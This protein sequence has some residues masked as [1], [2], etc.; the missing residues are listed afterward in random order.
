MLEQ[1]KTLKAEVEALKANH[2]ASSG[3]EASLMLVRQLASAPSRLRDHAMIVSALQRLA[4]DARC[5]HHPRAAEFEA[6]LRQTRPLS[7]RREFGDLIIRL[8]GT[9]EETSVASA[10]AKMV[11]NTGRPGAVP[12]RR[13]LDPRG[14]PG[15]RPI[16]GRLNCFNCGRPGHFQRHCPVSRFQNN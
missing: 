5:S 4:D 11:K 10:I 16:R 1:I 2:T 8:L 15:G 9:K 14:R 6:I 12:Y 7:F 13:P 3:V